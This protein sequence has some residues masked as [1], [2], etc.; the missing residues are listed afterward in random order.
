VLRFIIEAS[1]F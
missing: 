1:L